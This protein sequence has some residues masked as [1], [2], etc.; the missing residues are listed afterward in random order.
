MNPHPESK[1]THPICM[2]CYLRVTGKTSYT[3]VVPD[4]NQ[5]VELCC[6]CGRETATGVYYRAEPEAL[7]ATS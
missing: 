4:K 3:M 2:P 5:P 6:W 7:H 1:W